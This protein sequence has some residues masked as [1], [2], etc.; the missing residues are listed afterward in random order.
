LARPLAS[1]P[2]LNREAVVLAAASL[3]NAEGVEALSLS[4]LADR[5]GIQTPS[6]YNHVEGLP[7][8]QRE[9][10]LLNARQLGDCLATAAIGKSGP[11]AIREVAQAYRAYIKENRGLYE[12]SLRVAR[13]QLPVDDE[14]KS[15]ED[16][17]VKIG[18]AVVAS[19]GLSGADG[20]HAVRGLRSM[21]HGFASLE[22]AGGFS[23]PLDCDESFH[24]LVEMLIRGLAQPATHPEVKDALPALR[25][26]AGI[27]EPALMHDGLAVYDAGKG[28]PLL[29]MPYPHGFSR[30]PIIQGELAQIFLESGLRVVS[31]DPPG[32]FRSTRLAEVS[33]PEMLR[34]AQETIRALNLP[35][36]MVLAGHSMGGMCA[37]ALA[38][39][40]PE[41]VKKLILIGTLSGGSAISRHKGL[42]WGN[43]LRGM[44]RWKFTYY[45]MQLALG[46]GNLAV[47]KRLRRLLDQA[48]YVDKNLIPVVDIKK[49]DHHSPVPVRDRWA[50]V[51]MLRGI[52]Y[53]LRIDEITVPTLVCVGRFD[54]QAPVGCSR[55]LV[56]GIS[57]AHLEVFDHS[58]HYPF[59]EEKEK[60]KRLLI[61]FI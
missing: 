30:A 17:V 6:L 61:E 36:P 19:F 28:D 37:I 44:D 11:Q 12:A 45:G 55:E 49:E 15:A 21:V 22:V 42:P 52:D 46:L 60:F 51:V 3:L 41:L 7:G 38:L 10:A 24:R 27:D 4:R 26:P 13:I 16:R 9:L 29:L 35:G 2:V 47:H 57:G 34:C 50:R 31:F 40:H 54:P 59:I 1:R 58:G 23:L 14:L 25:K 33:M 56:E 53:R 5:L 43:W 32:M 48:S 20:L 8:L 39:E 18:L